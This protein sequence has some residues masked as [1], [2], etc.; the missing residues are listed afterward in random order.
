MKQTQFV[1]GAQGSRVRS[2]PMKFMQ[3]LVPP[4]DAEEYLRDGVPEL[5]YVMGSTSRDYFTIGDYQGNEPGESVRLPSL[6][7]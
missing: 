3:G 2:E 4:E 6:R 1:A 7:S 5:P